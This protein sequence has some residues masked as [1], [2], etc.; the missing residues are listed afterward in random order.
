MVLRGK[1][2]GGAIAPDA[3][4]VVHP[5]HRYCIFVRLYSRPARRSA[6]DG[7]RAGRKRPGPANATDSTNEPI[8]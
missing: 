8:P 4:V 6:R 1:T 3:R 7:G 5:F 2:S